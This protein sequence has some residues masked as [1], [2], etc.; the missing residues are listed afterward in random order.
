M[1]NMV[2]EELNNSLANQ[3]N[4]DA[5]RESLKNQIEDYFKRGGAVKPVQFGV[6]TIDDSK[7][8]FNQ[9]THNVKNPEKEKR[10]TQKKE[11]LAVNPAKKCQT[12]VKVKT[13]KKTVSK[14]DIDEISRR[15]KI[16]QLKKVAIA[17]GSKTFIGPCAVHKDTKYVIRASGVARCALCAEEGKKHKLDVATRAANKTRKAANQAGLK[18]AIEL[19]ET[20]FIGF[21]VN[22]GETPFRVRVSKNLGMSQTNFYYACIK[23]S[24]ESVRLADEKRKSGNLAK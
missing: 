13:P 24:Q 20:S 19:G 11:K 14:S 3:S 17:E 2:A 23:C 1:I 5:L 9:S 4:K 7:P 18:L 16:T 6:T 22:C 12:I 8:S 15:S 10:I 21:C